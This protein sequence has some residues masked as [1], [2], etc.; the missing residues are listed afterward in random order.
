LNKDDASEREYRDR[1]SCIP[2]L[3]LQTEV[4]IVQLISQ[5]LA[6]GDPDDY[7]QSNGSK[8]SEHM[9]LVCHIHCAKNGSILHRLQISVFGLEHFARLAYPGVIRFLVETRYMALIIVLYHSVI[10]S[11]DRT[12]AAILPFATILL[13]WSKASANQRALYR[14]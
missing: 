13:P 5:T 6:A 8:V 9:K 7:E 10:L 14:T 2:E 3:S 1:R 12:N 4:S 11:A